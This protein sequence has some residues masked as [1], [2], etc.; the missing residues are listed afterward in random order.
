LE[1]FAGQR[2]VDYVPEDSFKAGLPGVV[3]YR[4]REDYDSEQSV[5]ELLDRYLEEEGSDKTTALVIGAWEYDDMIEDPGSVGVVEA[6]VAASNRLPALR[7]LFLGD[8]TFQECEISWIHQS[9]I[10]PLLAAY[11]RLEEFRVRG[12]GDLTFGQLRHDRLRHLAI[13]SGGLPAE[14]LEELWSASLPNL[15]HLELWLGDPGYDGIEDVAPLEPL[16]SGQLFPGLRYLGLRNSHHADE[17]ARAV[18]ASPILDR[19]HILDLSLGNLSDEGARALLESPAVRR[20]E[21]LDLHH[22]YLSPKVVDE[23]RAL[24]NV[25]DVSDPQKPD[26]EYRYNAH[27]E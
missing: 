21:T 12:V 10:S 24:G 14:I 5:E 6:L 17:V 22:H 8:I 3:A 27:S 23:F 1:S 19:I 26:E 20:L 11:P 4:L 13:E 16:L 2:V 9:D 7:S 15:V 18:A 25:V